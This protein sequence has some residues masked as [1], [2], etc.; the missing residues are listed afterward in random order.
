MK[1]VLVLGAGL[2]ARPLVRYLLDKAGF[3]VTVASRTV[4]KGETMIAGHPHGTAKRFDVSKDGNLKE[5]VSEHDLVVSLLPYNYH[6]RVARAAI[7]SGK[8]MVTT[9]YVSEGMKELDRE[10][11]DAGVLLINEMGLDPGIDHMEAQRVIDE[12][13]QEGGKVEE[14]IS[15]CGGLPAPEANTNPW[16][17]KFSWSPRGVVLA[18]RNNA[19]F[20][21]DGVDV[22]IPGSELFANYEL[23]EVEGLG[24]FEGYPNRNS[25]PYGDIYGIPD[26]NTILRGTLRNR[27]WCDTWKGLHDIGM[28]EEVSPQA[29]DYYTMIDQLVP[30]RGDLRDRSKAFIRTRDNDLVVRNWEWLGL[31]DDRYLLDHTSRLD[32]LS[33]LLQEK[34]YYDRDERDMVVLQHT[35]N[36]ALGG[37]KRTLRSTMIDFGVPG[38]D[39]AMSRTVGIPAAIGV[40]LVLKGRLDHLD[41]V[42]IPTLPEIY[43]PALEELKKQGIF[44]K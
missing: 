17:Y 31:L 7:D 21:R 30:G 4:D 35:F 18:S 10:A 36:V 33:S 20:R 6:P 25:V 14:F 34:L 9:S 24:T 32:A 43:V 29:E 28:L 15:Y 22:E 42:I 41:G 23:V 16:G 40:E 12:V 13:H 3:Q 19:R 8:H 37:E 26:A 39:S 27:G 44:F 1:N 11:K 38:G 5:M 2:V